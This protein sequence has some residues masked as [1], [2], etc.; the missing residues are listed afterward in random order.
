MVQLQGT[1][2]NPHLLSHICH[3]ASDPEFRHNLVGYPLT[4]TCYAGM[5]VDGQMIEFLMYHYS[6][7]F[8]TSVSF[9]VWLLQVQ[10][11]LTIY[12]YYHRNYLTKF[13]LSKTH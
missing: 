11:I 6:C 4:C 13:S 5:T 12:L 3:V 7:T 10:F 8:A 1:N 2:N 9:Q